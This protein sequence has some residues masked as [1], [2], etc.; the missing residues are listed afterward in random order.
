MIQQ[1]LV[2]TK[3]PNKYLTIN[4][5][6]IQNLVDMILINMKKISKTR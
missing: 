3:L 2:N 1:N 5:M 6:I 4:I